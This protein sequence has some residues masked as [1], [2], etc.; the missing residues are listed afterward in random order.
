[1]YLRHFNSRGHRT[2]CLTNQSSTPWSWTEL[3]FFFFFYGST[4]IIDDGASRRRTRNARF[5]ARRADHS[6]TSLS[7]LNCC[8]VPLGKIVDKFTNKYS[9]RVY[10]V[11]RAS[12]LKLEMWIRRWEALSLVIHLVT[13]HEELNLSLGSDDWSTIYKCNY[14]V[15]PE[16]K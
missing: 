9:S 15:T 4:C 5:R 10:R 1:M 13:V 7:N 6:T 8:A 3:A 14:D 12:A 16:I 11:T 2:L